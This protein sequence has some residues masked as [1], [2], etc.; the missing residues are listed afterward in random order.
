MNENLNV[1]HYVR[2]GLCWTC[3][4]S[5]E[6]ARPLADAQ[7]SE[8]LRAALAS[9]RGRL[10]FAAPGE[11]VR[12]TSQLVLPEE[13]K[14]LARALPFMVEEEVADDIDAVHV[15][16]DLR[17][18]REATVMICAH[19]WMRRWREDLADL[20]R[21]D[22][23]VPEPLLL[24]WRSGEWCLV[25]GDDRAILRTGAGTGTAVE[26]VLLPAYLSAL[27]AQSAAP[28]AL[29]VYGQDRVGEL[30][31]LPGELQDLAQWR[32]GGFAASLWLSDAAKTLP[33]LLQGAYA[34]RLPLERWA[35]QWRWPAV[36]IA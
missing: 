12:L 36:A 19:A 4:G 1:L 30:A 6:P 22:T 31:Q 17:G 33:S 16:H 21:I 23:W 35:L 9:Q 5:G 26:R 18:G 32:S 27:L 11:A 25:F 20:P 2:G 28:Q 34:T 15:A 3:A 8:E 13:R 29:V 24:P 7:V 10:V 14:H